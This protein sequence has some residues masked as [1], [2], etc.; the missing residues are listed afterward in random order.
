MVRLGDSWRLFLG[1]MFLVQA[2]L[3]VM[4]MVGVWGD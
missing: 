2:L 3:R 4:R 1:A